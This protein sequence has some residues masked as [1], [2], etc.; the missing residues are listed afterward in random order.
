MNLCS[1]IQLMNSSFSIL[2]SDHHWDDR[3]NLTYPT[4]TRM[5]IREM[6]R[7]Q[8]QAYF[9]KYVQTPQEKETDLR[10]R[11]ADLEEKVEVLTNAV[12][13]LNKIL[14]NFLESYAQNP[15]A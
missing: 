7:A 14:K 9:E 1:E 13:S 6:T 5:G 4:I 11:V 8:Q 15:N 3:P 10:N 2:G 12:Y